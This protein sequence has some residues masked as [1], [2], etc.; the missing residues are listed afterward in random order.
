MSAIAQNIQDHKRLIAGRA[1]LIAV[2][3]NQSDVKIMQSLEAGQ[4]IFGENK[5]QEAKLHW[6]GRRKDYPDLTL[7]L[8][9]PLQSNKAK[10]AIAL[11]DAIQTIDRESLIDA[12][13]QQEQKQ[14]RRLDYFIQVN[15]GREEQKAGVMAENLPA[16]LDYARS[17]NLNVKGLMCIPPIDEDPRRHF[18]LLRNLA[19]ENALP[20]LSMGMSGDYKIA[21]EEGATFVRIG[22]ALFGER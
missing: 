17:K 16:V 19:K 7:H 9:G 4:R 5:V 14:D 18:G 21:I 12:L 8:I 10:D 3:K 2:S 22:T 13:A 1:K 11:F 6:E 15:T 20:E